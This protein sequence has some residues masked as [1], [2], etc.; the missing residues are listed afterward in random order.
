MDLNVN[1]YDQMDAGYQLFTWNSQDFM[2]YLDLEQQIVKKY[3]KSPVSK[4]AVSFEFPSVSIKVI[5]ESEDGG[6][7]LLAELIL[8]NLK[9]DMLQFLDYRKDLSF[10]AQTFYILTREA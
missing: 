2:K 8:Y 7:M 4:R 6:N 9:L 5:R 3:D 1:Y 10:K